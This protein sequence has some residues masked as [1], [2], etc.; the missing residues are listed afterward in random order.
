MPRV[1][2]MSGYEN[3]HSPTAN[4]DFEHVVIGVILSNGEVRGDQHR[5][6]ARACSGMTFGRL[7]DLKRHHSSLHG[8]AGGKG[9]RTWCPVDG[10]ESPFTDL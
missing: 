7:A 1:H 8:G 10:C 5:C 6:N 2:S 9:Q 4:S 3:I